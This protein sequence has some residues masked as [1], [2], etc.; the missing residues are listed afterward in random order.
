MVGTLAA[1]KSSKQMAWMFVAESNEARQQSV[2][3]DASTK[4]RKEAAN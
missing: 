3:M 4:A 2:I 1:K